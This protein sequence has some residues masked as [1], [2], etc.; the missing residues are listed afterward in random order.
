MGTRVA[1]LRDDETTMSACHHPDL[2]AFVAACGEHAI[3]TVVL[4]WRQE[5]GPQQVADDPT[6]YGPRNEVRLLAYHAGTIHSCDLS[7][8]DRDGLRADLEAA[9]LQVELRTRNIATFDRN[10]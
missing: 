2:Q 3:T 10:D 7:G 1:P 8:V 6:D 4:T 9:G 5:W